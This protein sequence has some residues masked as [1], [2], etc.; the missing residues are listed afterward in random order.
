MTRGSYTPYVLF[1]LLPGP[2]YYLLGRDGA[3]Y[4]VK[5]YNQSVKIVRKT[6]RAFDLVGDL[7]TYG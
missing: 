3:S 6:F 4:S 5:S 2:L 1:F 7:C